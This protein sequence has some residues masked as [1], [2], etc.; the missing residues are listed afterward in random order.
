MATS[1]KPSVQQ[2]VVLGGVFLCICRLERNNLTTNP[3]LA[4]FASYETYLNE[5]YLNNMKQ[6]IGSTNWRI[7]HEIS[8]PYR[9]HLVALG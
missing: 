7:Y 8:A 3:K 6:K 4:V 5:H 1:R 2:T 9:S